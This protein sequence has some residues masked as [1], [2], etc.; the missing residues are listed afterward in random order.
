MKRLLIKVIFI[1]GIF[2]FAIITI[3]FINNLVSPYKVE[4]EIG[5]DTKEVF[6]NGEYQFY[7]YTDKRL[8]LYNMK[9]NTLMINSVVNYIEKDDKVYFKG[10]VFDKN[11]KSIEVLAVLEL[12]NNNLIKYYTVDCPFDD[13]MILYINQIK[14]DNKFVVINNFDEFETEEQDILSQL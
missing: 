4:Y 14:N 13:Y 9:Y 5:F 6:G 3:I 8:Y 11:K 7:S 1:V 10:Y 12:K 2:A